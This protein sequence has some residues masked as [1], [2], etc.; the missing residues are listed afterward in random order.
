MI[1]AYSSTLEFAGFAGVAVCKSLSTAP[2]KLGNSSCGQRDR[3]IA[4]AEF[5]LGHDFRH[6][7]PGSVIPPVTEA[8]FAELSAWIEAN[9]ERLERLA[10]SS[11]LFDVGRGRRTC[12]GN[13]RFALRDGPRAPA[14]LPR[15]SGNYGRDMGTKGHDRTSSPSRSSPAWHLRHRAEWSCRRPLTIF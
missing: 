1:D 4:S 15:T 12:C 10:D 3:D 13:V 6:G 14:R 5:A 8:E 9:A 2:R 7:L 11:G